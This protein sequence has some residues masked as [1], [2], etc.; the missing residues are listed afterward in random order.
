MRILFV[1]DL[2][3]S[4]KQFDWL[5][6]AISD[7]DAVVIGGDLLDLGGHADLD[8]QIVVVTKYLRRLAERLPVAVCSGNHDLDAESAAGE[9]CAEWL[10]H[11][12]IAQVAVDTQN[13]RQGDCLFS[14]C[15]WWEGPAAQAR[16]EALLEDAAR[17][18]SGPWIWI[19][20]APP[21]GAKTCWNG[22]AFSGDA[23]LAGLI[24]KHQPDLV[25]S[26]HIHASPFRSEGHWC[27]RLGTTWVFNPGRLMSS[28]PAT[29][30]IDLTTLQAT[31]TSE[32]DTQTLN[33]QDG[34]LASI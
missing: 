17:D 1:S 20:H 7:H 16:I 22:K 25:L 29:I 8:T 14:V 32:M 26:G 31:W 2:H 33:L 34:T 12:E 6:D 19:Y 23:F 28:I 10:E 11:L 24:A 15:P 4:L 30:D 9:R 3:Y 5:C 18:R 21:E 13:Y 27:D